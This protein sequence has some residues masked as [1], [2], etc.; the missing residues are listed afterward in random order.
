MIRPA[1]RIGALAAGLAVLL[2]GAPLQAEEPI[3]PSAFGAYAEGYTLYFTE[4]GEYFGAETYAPGRTTLW[5]FRFGDCVRGTWR[6]HGGQIC[7]RYEDG[8]G[9]EICWR[10][11]RDEKGLFARLLG[12]GP[13]AGMELRVVRR[14]REPLRCGGPTA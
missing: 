9:E 11:L 4:G 8:D 1:P 7:F 6:A 13:D 2:L 5:Q 10:M 12:D 3:S 14:D